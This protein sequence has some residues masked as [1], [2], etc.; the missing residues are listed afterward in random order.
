MLFRSGSTD[1]PLKLDN[2]FDPKNELGAAITIMNRDNG[3]QV[4]IDGTNIFASTDRRAVVVYQNCSRQSTYTP[5]FSGN[6]L[7]NTVAAAAFAKVFANA[8][9]AGM[10]NGNKAISVRCSSTTIRLMGKRFHLIM[11]M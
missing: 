5:T 8:D 6:E 4:K 11:S 7:H 10:G 3:A 1:K 9:K 2:G